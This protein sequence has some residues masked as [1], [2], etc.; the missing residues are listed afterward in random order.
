[1]Q[2]ISFCPKRAEKMKHFHINL[3]AGLT[4]EINCVNVKTTRNVE[5]TCIHPLCLS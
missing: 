2:N 3:S 4:W 1:M 5:K